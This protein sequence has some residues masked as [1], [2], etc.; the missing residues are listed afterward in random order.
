M[1]PPRFPY[2]T[3]R[4]PPIQHQ[5][6]HHVPSQIS[7]EEPVIPLYANSKS[8]HVSGLDQ[9][10]KIMKDKLNNHAGYGF[11]EF[12]DHDTA[13]FAKEN[14][15]GRL[16]HGRELK[17]NWTYEASNTTE[18]GNVYKLF[19]GGLHPEVNDDILYR[20]FK[21]FGS[22][23]GA[24]VLRNAQTGKSKGY[25]FISFSIKEDADNALEMM[26]GEKIEGRTIKVNWVTQNMTGRQGGTEA[27]PRSFDEVSNETTKTNCTVYVGNIPVGKGINEDML[28]ELFGEYGEIDDIRATKEKGYAFIRFIN[29][30]CATRAIMFLNGHNFLGSNIR[31][32]WGRE[33]PKPN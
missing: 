16:V 13:T 17:V 18:T 27:P 28:R 33:I 6:Q 20:H 25:G 7:A 14:M 5:L 24:R 23:T 2:N 8:L 9:N 29:H 10:C 32:S 19:V 22:L 15:D 3:Q 30:D 21:K 11:V 26:N 4:P 12:V 31:C 1:Y